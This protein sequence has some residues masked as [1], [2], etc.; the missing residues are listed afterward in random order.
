[1]NRTLAAPTRTSKITM[2]AFAL[3]GVLFAGYAAAED[4][5]VLR[6]RAEPRGERQE[7]AV[8]DAQPLPGAD[9][10]PARLF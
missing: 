3:S 5:R 6:E 2:A 8:R 10:R 4:A 1:M 9:V 7:R